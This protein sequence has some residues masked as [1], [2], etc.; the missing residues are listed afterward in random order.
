MIKDVDELQKL[1]NARISEAL[2]GRPMCQPEEARAVV[3]GILKGI[4]YE[5]YLEACRYVVVL[6]DAHDVHRLNI[7]AVNAAGPRFAHHCNKCVYLGGT[8]SWD[9]YVCLDAKPWPSL[10]ARYGDLGYEYLS[11]PF[12]IAGAVTSEL[13]VRISYDLAAQRGLLIS[14]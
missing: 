13:A 10:I 5:P 1:L 4:A 14:P 8:Q 6:K 11:A 2:I 7:F 9:H 12:S 3:S